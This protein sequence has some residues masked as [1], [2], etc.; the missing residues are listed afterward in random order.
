MSAAFAEGDPESRKFAITINETTMNMIQRIKWKMMGTM[1]LMC[2]PHFC[3]Y[4][5]KEA[6]LMCFFYYNFYYVLLTIC[7]NIKKKMSK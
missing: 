7:E 4:F 6:M 5:S 1:E 2:F 3:T